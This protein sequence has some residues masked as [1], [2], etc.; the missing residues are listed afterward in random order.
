LSRLKANTTGMSPDNK[1]LAIGNTPELARAHNSHAVPQPPRAAVDRSERIALGASGRYSAEAFHFVSYVP[2]N[3]RL[4]ELDGLK[5]FPIDHGPWTATED[6]TELFRRVIL[7]R[8]GSATSGGEPY[9]DIRFSLMVVVPDKRL[10]ISQRLRLLKTNKRIVQEALHQL[11][12]KNKAKPT[13]VQDAATEE[14]LAVEVG[15]APATFRAPVTTT[16]T[17]QTSPVPSMSSCSTDTASE[18]GSAFNSPTETQRHTVHDVM[19]TTCVKDFSRLVVVK[20][21]CPTDGEA[22]I[23]GFLHLFVLVCC[24][25]SLTSLES[26]ELKMRSPLLILYYYQRPND[27][28][29]AGLERRPPAAKKP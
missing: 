14:S 11:K 23:Q 25:P 17:I 8:I 28:L 7:E 12:P 22:D 18:S 1:G 16:L 3:G 10:A 29:G 20:I 6:W 2:I 5:P 24:S 13:A 4:Y 27:C 26:L 9:H 19:S 21:D 15:T